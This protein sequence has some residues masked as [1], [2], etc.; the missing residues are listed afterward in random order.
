MA[1]QRAPAFVGRARE[2]QALDRLL[3]SVRGGESAA[4]VIRGEAGIGKTA[5]LHY[6]ARQASGCRVARLAGVESELELPFAALHQLCAPM[7][8]DLAALPEP[9]RRALRVAFG[10][11]TGSTPD[12]FLVGL[13]VLSLLAEGAAARPLVCL[14]DD[15]QW[16]DRASAQILGLVGRRLVAE[17]VA[18]VFAVRES[19]DE[20]LFPALP[21]MT[22]EG[23]TAEDARA[24]LT[25]AVPGHLDERVRDR[26]VAETGGNPLA[27]LELVQVVSAAELAGGFALPPAMGLPGHLHDHYLGRVQ[28]LPE[29]TRRMRLLA[30]ADPTGDA[31]LLWRAARAL[32]I[33]RQEA[34]AAEAGQLLAIGARVRFRHP[35]VRSAA[36]AAGSPQER[37]SAHRALAQA[38]D[39]RA[40]PERRVWHL[41]AAA[42]GPDEDV[43]ADL[44][45]T[46]ARVQSRAGLA[47]AAAFLQRSVAL[48]GAPARRAE[49]ALAA[50]HA[51]L[52][53]G[54]FDAALGL[55]A[56]AEAA[57]LND[58]QRARVE[59]LA[60][61]V[62]RASSSGREA[63]TRLLR[64]A[65]R[66]EALDVRLARDTYLDALFASLVAGRL[67]EPGAHL[68]E[69]AKAARSAA[70]PRA[71]LPRDLLLDGL[72][73]LI[74]DGHAAAEAT[75]RR[76]VHAFLADRVAIDDWLQG[77]LLGSGAAIALWDV[78]SWATLSARHLEFARASGALAPLSAA[79]NAQRVMAI[80]RGDFESATSLGV[81]EAA[82]K[83]V[84]RV[85][86]TS[87]GDLLLAAYR[88][89]AAE[90]SR[91]IAAT[92]DDAIARGEGLGL[93]HANW[94]TAILHN[95]LGRYADA[96]SAAEH[97][98]EENYAPF[99]TACV[100][101]E[102]VEAAVRSGQPG[103]AADRLR[104]LLATTSITGADW[105]GGIEARARALLSEGEPA[106]R[107]YIEAVERLG[108][109]PPRSDLARA[110][111][112]YGEWLRREGRR[113]DARQQ[114][115][116]AYDLFAAMGAEAFAQRARRELLATGEKVRKRDVDTPTELTP[117][118]EHIARL[119]RDGRTNPEI[120]A[121]LFL[122][123]RTVEWHLR[124]VFTKLG[125]TS[126][127]GLNDALLPTN[128]HNT[129][130][131][132]R[133]EN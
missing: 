93:Q 58:L 1:A 12:R 28:A 61:Q 104:Q 22:V 121:E 68:P 23:L 108:R 127:K 59:Q 43:A 86:K 78:D 114:L 48:T 129:H 63:P 128:R 81:E 101:P 39:T 119:A 10:L 118:E 96:C 2:R 32:G 85:R 31:A 37:S 130:E 34:A 18:L 46:A 53:A 126:R 88:G 27:L 33:G 41:A 84:T 109:T 36:Y 99:I 30:A 82:V 79:L 91:L 3:D 123:A 110:H 52:H 111:L 19:A 89:R 4:L 103:L 62:D 83:E 66:L 5:L 107:C 60:G 98:A 116:A 122:S 125:I 38:T 95:G 76:A 131:L 6:C 24:F 26:L 47:G 7:L 40:D 75:L 44:E 106:E 71:P 49:R 15:A 11:A 13:A 102:M 25:A 67:A 57:A 21:T 113:V 20:R 92:V 94:A 64:A 69:V 17:S 16:L 133:T 9:Q 50:A 77:G 65:V 29:S 35:L 45:R 55:L 120:A 100:L 72:A 105:A 117:Q 54:A 74:I 90:A 51:N 87:Y 80:L 56:E 42:T 132:H 14:V 70:Q 115:R 73:T 97:A 124:K 8:G 112:L